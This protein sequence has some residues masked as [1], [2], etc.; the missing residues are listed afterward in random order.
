MRPKNL[1]YFFQ[2][3]VAQGQVHTVVATDYQEA[4]KLIEDLA[5]FTP[6]TVTKVVRGP[7]IEAIGGDY[8]RA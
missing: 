3:E 2:A 5:T 7:R 6:G 1:L 8:G 4:L